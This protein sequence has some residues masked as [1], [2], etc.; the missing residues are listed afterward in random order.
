MTTGL[1]IDD[2]G[3]GVGS[4]TA[5]VNAF[6]VPVATA[7]ADPDHALLVALML[8]IPNSNVSLL[9]SDPVGMKD[10]YRD[11]YYVEALYPLAL[12]PSRPTPTNTPTPTFSATEDTGLRALKWV[13][14]SEV[15]LQVCEFINSIS[16]YV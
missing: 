10:P 4:S 3:V 6:T 16:A 7:S 12:V 8:A 2:G 11:K 15:V 14:L 9:I 13:Q 5:V 1:K